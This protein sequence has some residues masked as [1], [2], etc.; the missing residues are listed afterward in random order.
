MLL[1]VFRWIQYLSETPVHHEHCTYLYLRQIMAWVTKRKTIITLITETVAMNPTL[2]DLHSSSAL[3]SEMVEWGLSHPCF[4]LPGL[5]M[6][7]IDMSKAEEI[8]EFSLDYSVFTFDLYTR[9]SIHCTIVTLIIRISSSSYTISLTPGLV[10]WRYP[11]SASRAD[12]CLIPSLC[13]SAVTSNVELTVHS[14]DIIDWAV[15]TSGNREW[16]WACDW[17]SGGRLLLDSTAVNTLGVR[18][19]CRLTRLQATGYGRRGTHH[20]ASTAFHAKAL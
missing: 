8:L 17:N 11:D 1:H 3:P 4:S 13:V 16:R 14:V 5:I 9:S 7:S 18:N 15:I 2:F 20:D 10:S 6:W 19:Q 12:D